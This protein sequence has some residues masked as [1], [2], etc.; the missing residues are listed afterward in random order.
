L[1]WS[2]DDGDVVPIAPRYSQRIFDAVRALDDPREPMAETCRRVGRAAEQMGLPRPSY[3][4]LRR[5]IKEERERQAAIRRVVHDVT[6]DLLAGKV[7]HP[8]HVLQRLD[9][10]TR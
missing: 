5:F 4:H 9:D 6:S 2:G 7:P 10:A 8:H 1:E 3:S